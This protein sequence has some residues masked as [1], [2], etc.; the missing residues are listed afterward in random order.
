MIIAHFNTSAEGGAAVLMLRLHQA[1]LNT[2]LESQIYYRKGQLNT[3]NSHQL[4]FIQTP[5]AKFLERIE[6]KLENKLLRSSDNLFSLL[7]SPVKTVLPLSHRIADIYHLHWISHWIDL[8]SFI[9]SLPPKTPIVLTLHDFGNLTGGCHLYS[10][11]DRFESDC[12]P[13]PL[14]KSPFDRFLAYQELN[15]KR[16]QFGL[17]PVYVVG[18]SEWTTNLATT[19]AVFRNAVTF[20]TIHPAIEPKD[21]IRYEKA[22]AKKILGISP[23]KLV[24]G[25]GCAELT[26]SNKNFVLFLE[27]LQRLKSHVDLEAVVFG[28]GLRLISEPPVPIHNLGK[29]ASNRLLSIAY[30]AMDIFAITSRIETFSQVALEAQAC[31]TPICAFSVGGLPDAVDDGVTGFL[32]PFGD[33]QSMMTQSLMLLKD[34][35]KAKAFSQA[36]YER[37]RT[38]FTMQSVVASY[39][40]LYQEALNN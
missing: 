30:S 9:A 24:L 12:L 6:F 1:L 7:R 20:R 39:E 13:C 14:L 26:D 3:K 5:I 11:C 37:V 16:A 31:G 32:S 23:E 36:G 19:A 33:L 35:D 10:G 2:G 18:N 22:E 40:D 15:R 27:L 8:P 21:F 25:F 28:N 4:E 38:R 34:S 29:L 17:R